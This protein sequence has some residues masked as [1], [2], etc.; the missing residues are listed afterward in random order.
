MKQYLLS[1]VEARL[2]SKLRIQIISIN[3]TQNK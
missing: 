1:S 2:I 3:Q